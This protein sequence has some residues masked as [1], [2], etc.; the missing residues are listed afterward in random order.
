ML[1]CLLGDADFVEVFLLLR[2]LKLVDFLPFA[3]NILK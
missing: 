3:K 1:G 2:V